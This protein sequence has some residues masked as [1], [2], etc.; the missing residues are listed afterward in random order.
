MFPSAS[1]NLSFPPL[2]YLIL[3]ES[4]ACDGRRVQFW[5]PGD[6]EVCIKVL[7]QLTRLFLSSLG[8]RVLACIIIQDSYKLQ[9][10]GKVSIKEG[11]TLSCS[12][13][14]CTQLYNLAA[15]LNCFQF[16]NRLIVEN[17]CTSHPTS[18]LVTMAVFMLA[19]SAFSLLF[20]NLKS[21]RIL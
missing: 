5:G 9:F 14:T 21:R 1:L 7:H 17:S 13:A 3:E 12:S 4:V 16:T 11:E 6:L 19:Q 8:L 20:C 15:I 18:P 10:S 2:L